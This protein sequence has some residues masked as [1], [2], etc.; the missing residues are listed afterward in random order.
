MIAFGKRKFSGWESI[1][2]VRLDGEIIGNISFPGQHDLQLKKFN[3]DSSELTYRTIDNSGEYKTYYYNIAS[4]N[5]TEIDK[6]FE[7]EKNLTP[8]VVTIDKEIYKYSAEK[9]LILNEPDKTYYLINGKNKIKLISVKEFEGRIINTYYH[10]TNDEKSFIFQIQAFGY[11]DFKDYKNDIVGV[12][13]INLDG[14]NLQ[15]LPPDTPK[16]WY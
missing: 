2:V 5:L 6:G 14:T 1:E 12:Y 8:K 13:K 3:Q 10:F 16:Q 7:K 9:S 4:K 15:K 11:N